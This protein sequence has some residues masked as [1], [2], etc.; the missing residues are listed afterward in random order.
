MNSKSIFFQPI[1]QNEIKNI[2]NNMENKNR[3]NN[4]INAKTLKTV[5][6]LLVDLLT[7]IFNLCIDKAIWTDALKLADV[8]PL[9]K[10]KEKH[11]AN[12]YTP[13]FL[14]SNIAKVLEKN[15]TQK[16]N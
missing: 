6:E 5:A 11:I 16:N 13:T 12:N 2:I 3:R 15:N 10:S 1:N 7:H 9:H 8:N 14:V 4:N